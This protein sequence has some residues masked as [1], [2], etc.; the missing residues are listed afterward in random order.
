MPFWGVII[1]CNMFSKCAEVLC[2][3]PKYNVVLMCLM[4]TVCVL[5]KLHSVMNYT[6]EFDFSEQYILNNLFLSRNTHNI[7]FMY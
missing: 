5:D 1:L 4:A 3:V 7:N 6:V 2:S